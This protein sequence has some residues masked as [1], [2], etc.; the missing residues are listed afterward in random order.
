MSLER[1]DIVEETWPSA[2]NFVLCRSDQ[3]QALISRARAAGV[4][5]RDFSTAPGLEGCVRISVG[6]PEENAQLISGLEA[7]SDD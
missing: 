6:T 7:V 3:P 4:L 2:A 5:V 1:V